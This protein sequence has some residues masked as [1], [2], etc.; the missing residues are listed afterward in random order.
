MRTCVYVWVCAYD[1][2]ACGGQERAVDALEMEL[3]GAE[4]CSVWVLEH[5]SSSLSHFPSPCSFPFQ[6]YSS[7]RQLS[8]KL[9]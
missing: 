5:H 9:T 3:Q 4:R 2:N 6:N 1:C 7:D 8:N